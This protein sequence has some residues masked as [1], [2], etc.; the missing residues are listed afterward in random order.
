MSTNVLQQKH[1]LYSRAFK[2]SL[3]CPVL[4]GA[5]FSWFLACQLLPVYPPK[6]VTPRL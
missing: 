1:A 4:Y 6:L 5:L 2:G 3:S